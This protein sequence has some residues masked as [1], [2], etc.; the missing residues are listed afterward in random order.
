MALRR[1]RA[2]V[3]LCAIF[4]WDL[5]AASLIVARIVVSRRAATRP[6]IIAIPVH[7]QKPW[8]V[9]LYA[10]FTSLTPGSTCLHVSNDRRHLYV[11]LLDSADPDASAARFR[12]LYERWIV[13]LER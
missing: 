1:I 2:V 10:Y 9:A 3:A 8:A 7:V 5:L 4:L 12:R 13:D 6:G 11:H